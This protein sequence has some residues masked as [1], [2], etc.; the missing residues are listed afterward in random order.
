ME[1]SA[2]IDELTLITIPFSEVDED[3]S[4]FT[5]LK[6][7]TGEVVQI[8]NWEKKHEMWRYELNLTQPLEFGIEY[9]IK[10]NEHHSFQVKM[11]KVVRTLDFDEH[12]FYNGSD[13]GATYTKS[14]TM[15][16]VWAPT[17]TAVE[18][19][20][21]QDQVERTYIMNHCPRGV[22]SYTLN[23]ELD[24]TPYLYQ[25]FIDGDWRNAVDPY[26][27]AVTINGEMGVVVNLF[28]T[29]PC[30]WRM[31]K[32]PELK[33]FTDAIIYELHVRDFSIDYHSGITA[34]GKYKGLTETG[35]KGPW[36]TVTGLDYLVDLGVT[37]VQLLPVQDYGSVDET[38]PFEKYN[39]GY[40][41]VHFQAV[42]GSYSTQ[43]EQPLKR[44]TELKEVVETFHKQG[45]R[46]ILDVVFNHVY[47]HASSHLENTVPGYY[48]RYN[49][50]GTLADGTGVGNDVASERK[51]ARK[52][53]VDSII[54]L[55]GEFNVDGF[56]FDLMGNLDVE[57]MNEIRLKLDEIDPTLL[58]IGEG[59]D[60]ATPLASEKKAIIANNHQLQGISHFND[61][62]RDKLKGNIFDITSQ[63]FCNGNSEEK[64]YCKLLVSGSIK[65]FYPIG[66][67]FQDPYQSVNYVECHDNHTLWDKLLYA[68]PT[69]SETE[70]ALM[71]RLATT[72]TLL[73]QGI[74]FIHAGQEFFRTKNGVENSY[75]SL[76]DVNKLDWK[77]KALHMDNVD[78]LKSVIQI[79]K[80]FEVFRFL[81]SDL[82]RKN[83]HILD[84]PT[85]IVAYMMKG[86]EGTFVIAHNGGKVDKEIV[87][88]SKGSW[89]VYVESDQA[90]T[91]PLKIIEGS[92]AVIKKISTSV[93]LLTK[94]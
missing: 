56:R 88:P 31:A 74:P 79:R 20:L 64:D 8:K 43:P 45:L 25:L 34:K 82:V 70:K 27:K 22:W 41:T 21:H 46:V 60:L 5:L 23:G 58:V 89:K 54:Y 68:N 12:Y 40:D 1:K 47:I 7:K 69:E 9:I 14:S 90:S 32:R 28:K 24:G 76:D 59:W 53:I 18:L 33:Q 49:M 3:L 78:Y 62:F 63:G 84:T 71:H 85:D 39:W 2:Y 94:K 52:L 67:V 93:L 50:D 86:I 83:I 19:V 42:E 44:I 92:K 73:S 26:A 29:N 87:L 61:L 48:F 66:G 10:G 17:A 51:M 57:T 15:F 55:A 38:K 4:T 16:K 91:N 65:D 13:L 11:G 77:R 30:Q 81:T 80:K 6:K 37:H 75:C 72:M 35:T 36:G